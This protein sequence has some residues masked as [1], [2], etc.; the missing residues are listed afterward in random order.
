MFQDIAENFCLEYDDREICGEDV[1]L[2]YCGRKILCRLDGTSVVLPCFKDIKTGAE[3]VNIFTVGERRFFLCLGKEQSAEGF[4]YK[5]INLIKFAAVSTEQF[6]A[7]TG[8]HYF[9]FHTE[10]KFCGKCGSAV[11]HDPHKRCMICESC[12]N[13]IFPKISPAVIVGVID[14]KNDSIVLTKYAQGEYKRYALVAG[15]AEM[16]ETAEQ[17]A[18][19][20][21]MEETGLEITGLIY[22]KSQPWGFAQ[23]LLFGFFAKVKGSRN[24]VRDETELSEALWVKREDIADYENSVS[25]THEMM[26]VFKNGKVR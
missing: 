7:V 20:E 4:E 11:Y 1:V 19:R 15:F 23:N 26:R 12:K 9:C 18:R 10:N 8:F 25:L 24:I 16:G 21:V 17:A 3:M 14:E 6:A 13:E 5:D 22:Y 2:S